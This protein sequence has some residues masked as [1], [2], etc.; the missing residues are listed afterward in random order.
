MRHFKKLA[1]L[2]CVGALAACSGDGPSEI[3]PVA[4]CDGTGLGV[5]RTL[6]VAVG[7]GPLEDRLDVGEVILT[8]D[9][10]PVKD[11]TRGSLQA[12]ADHCTHATF[13][14]QGDRS[15]EYPALVRQIARAGHS[16]GGHSWNHAYLTTMSLTEARAD[17]TRGVD[18]IEA[19]TAKLDTHAGIGLFR[20]P[21]L[22]QT[23]ELGRLITDLG[24]VVIGVTADAEDWTGNSPQE[25]VDLVMSKI[26]AAGGKGVILLHDPFEKSVETTALLL[27]RLQAE[28]YRIVALKFS[29]KT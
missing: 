22:A 16:L 1:S 15:E 6:T 18:A 14:L 20:F 9:D 27:D 2:F 19:A 10:G 13:F 7:D 28:N 25:R 26:S 3:P 29:E 23:D 24:M 21:Y 8:F 17:I 12:L 11:L 4:T 5:S